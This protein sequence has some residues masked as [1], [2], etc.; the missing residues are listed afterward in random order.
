MFGCKSR[1]TQETTQYYNLSEPIKYGQ[2]EAKISL[3]MEP[4]HNAKE[5]ASASYRL[6]Q[7]YGVKE[8]RNIN[9]TQNQ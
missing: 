4:Y 3:S 9:G 8:S 2:H 5:L 1:S 6:K 7:D